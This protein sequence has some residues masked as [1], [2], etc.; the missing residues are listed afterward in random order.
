M[1][2]D[3]KVEITSEDDHPRL[4][5]DCKGEKIDPDKHEIGNDVKAVTYHDFKLTQ[6]G[7]KW[8]CY[9]LLDI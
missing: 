6:E 2:S 5:A 8:T 9:V 1:F 3:I 4:E 7:D